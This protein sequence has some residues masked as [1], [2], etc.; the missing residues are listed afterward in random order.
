MSEY[1]VKGEVGSREDP[2]R[3]HQPEQVNFSLPPMHDD[4]QVIFVTPH[5]DTRGEKKASN[6]KKGEGSKKKSEEEEKKK[7]T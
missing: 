1:H 2:I 7:V 5:G 3:H 6:K 4:E